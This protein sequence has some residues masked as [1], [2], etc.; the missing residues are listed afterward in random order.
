MTLKLLCD[1]Q[2]L[3]DTKNFKVKV[4]NDLIRKDL[5]I[6]NWMNWA[7]PRLGEFKFYSDH[8]LELN[9]FDQ[10]LSLLIGKEI[11]YGEE[12]ME[13][14]AT[15][16]CTDY[17]YTN[18]SNDNYSKVYVDELALKFTNYLLEVS[19]FCLYADEE[20]KQ[21]HIDDL[22]G[23]YFPDYKPVFWNI[24]NQKHSSNNA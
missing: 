16:K 23:K 15:Y 12:S 7:Y 22:F 19:F 18:I 21:K 4:I 11:K 20:K 1:S 5:D 8:R 10:G 24:N 2:T 13:S 3:A 9:C 6:F 14:Y 17:L